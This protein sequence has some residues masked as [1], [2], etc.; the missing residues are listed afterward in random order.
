M[1][2]NFVE[3]NYSHRRMTFPVGSA[4]LQ[5]RQARGGS[6][7]SLK[8]EHFAHYID[9]VQN[10]MQSLLADARDF[11]A[12]HTNQLFNTLEELRLAVE[13]L[14]MAEEELIRQNEE[15]AATRRLAEAE[16][17]RYQELFEG[18]PDGYIVTNAQGVV[19]EANRV[20]AALLQASPKLLSGKPLVTQVAETERKAFHA[21]LNQMATS[22]RVQG[23]ELTLQ[24]RRQEPIVVSVTVETVQN[25][26]NAPHVLRWQMRDIS[27]LKQAEAALAQLQAQNLELIELDRLRNQFLATVSHELKTPM[28]AI[29]GFS[30]MLMKQFHSQPDPRTLT[31]AERIFQN[32]RHLLSLIED[33]LNFARLQ[34]NSMALN[35][36]SLD[37]N[38]LVTTTLEEL[39]PL[40][41][42]KA[43]RLEADLPDEPV[44]VVND[45][46]R[47]RQ[48][49]TNLVSNAVKFTDVGWVVV[50]LQPIAGGRVRLQVSDTGCGIAPED[51]PQ[52]F[53]E[54]WQVQNS[55]HQSLGTG[56][57]LAIVHALV[58]AMQGTVT[59]VSDLG[60][61]TTFHIELPVQV[62]AE[63]QASPSG[64]R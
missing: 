6:V 26:D 31:M 48:I 8:D 35:L 22:R 10:R 12:S 59:V 47:L 54:F 37:L 9:T 50:V 49:L 53:Q 57:G 44:I 30:Q 64:G 11:P 51:Q 61:G 34:A 14:H 58:Q 13:E 39:R 46:C 5:S 52:V 4:N 15:L 36:E 7:R 55:R 28:N 17:Y 27:D 56:L 60:H 16:R 25:P 2:D 33:M 32:G 63:P 38:E 21:L 19:E 1:V 41:D 62:E 23:W 29:L 18:A 43:L 20:A 40:A 45:R 24:G 3:N 42:Q